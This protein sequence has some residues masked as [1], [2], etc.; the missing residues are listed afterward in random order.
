MTYVEKVVKAAAKKKKK[1]SPEVI[2][3]LK[4]FEKMHDIIKECKITPSKDIEKYHF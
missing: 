4:S 1:V 3:G 2:E